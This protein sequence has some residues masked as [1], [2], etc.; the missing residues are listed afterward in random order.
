MAIWS[1]SR[2][3]PSGHRLR[4]LSGPEQCVTT[5]R[6][7]LSHPRYQTVDYTEADEGIELTGLICLQV[8]RGPPAESHYRNFE[9]ETLGGAPAAANSGESEG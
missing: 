1:E 3:E 5:S 8:H 9:M 4:P 7:H 6:D 2:S